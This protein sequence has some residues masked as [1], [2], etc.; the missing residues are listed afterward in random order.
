[1]TD[2]YKLSN[3]KYLGGLEYPKN[4]KTLATESYHLLDEDLIYVYYSIH[5]GILF[6]N[7]TTKVTEKFETIKKVNYVASESDYEGQL[8]LAIITETSL[9]IKKYSESILE[10]KTFVKN[11]NCD[12]VFVIKYNGHLFCVY[13]NLDDNK[14]YCISSEDDFESERLLHDRSFEKQSIISAGFDPVNNLPTV[15]LEV[16]DNTLLK[17]IDNHLNLDKN[18]FIEVLTNHRLFKLEV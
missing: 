18:K 16:I 9:I 13:L 6:K 15:Y 5:L 12:K 10:Y 2:I 11:I 3:Y 8:F 1:M 17:N 14:I 4:L 7:M